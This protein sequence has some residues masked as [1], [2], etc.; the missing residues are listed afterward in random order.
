MYGE[1]GRI[2]P[3]RSIVRRMS[4]EALAILSGCVHTQSAETVRNGRSISRQTA[5]QDIAWHLGTLAP[6]PYEAD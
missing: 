4:K 5:W 2:E 6:W 1:L 3:R